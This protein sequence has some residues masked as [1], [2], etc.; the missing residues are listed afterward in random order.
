M[1][2]R[3][4]SRQ[5]D[6]SDGFFIQNILPG[7]LVIC[8]PPSTKEGLYL[9]AL[10]PGE[11]ADLSYYDAATL[12]KS[13]ALN[14]ALRNGFAVT[15][16]ENEYYQQ[17]DIAE[18]RQIQAN[19]VLQQQVS[20][21]HAAG[22]VFEAEQI[23][24]ATAGNVHGDTSAEALL[25]QKNTLSNPQNWADNYAAA[26]AQGLVNDPITF[27][28]L[29]ESGKISFQ[30]ATGNRGRRVSL[31]EM[32]NVNA[33]D[34]MTMTAT[35]ATIAMPGSYNVQGQ[36]GRPEERGGVYTQKRDLG[37]WNANA[38]LP[39]A[40]RMGVIDTENAVYPGQ[41]DDGFVEDVDLSQDDAA[42]NQQTMQ[43]Q[44]QVA[45]QLGNKGPYVGRR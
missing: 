17:M 10:Q 32:Q 18:Q 25:A 3:Y 39:G 43:Q 6:N 36:D 13:R 31:A 45:Q 34:Q 21:A 24:L 19:E 44:Q 41:Q 33:Q 16:S 14:N 4:N 28:Q 2:K 9:D 5:I 30:T 37:N 40:N 7:P 35:Q 12:N 38:S 42:Y 29:V 23:N 26:K 8:D 20:E 1:Q 11:T 27:Q 22:S 15:L